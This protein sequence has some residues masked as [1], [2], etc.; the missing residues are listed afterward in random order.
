MGGNNVYDVEVTANDNSGETTVQLIA[1]TVTP[2]NDNTPVFTTQGGTGS[3][4]DGPVSSLVTFNMPENSTVA[5]TVT[6]TD[7]DLPAQE[8]TFSITGGADQ[9]LFTVNPETGVLSFLSA[10][11]FENPADTGAN[12][13]YEVQVTANDGQGNMTA[14]DVTVNV[15]NAV[16]V[17]GITLNPEAGTYYLGKE[18]A[19]VDPTATYQEDATAADYSSAQLTVSIIVNRQAKDTLSIKGQGNKP[20]Q[21]NTK[22]KNILFGGVVIGTFKGGTRAKPE[23][24]ITFNSSATEAA[25]NAL[26]KRITFFSKNDR[27][28]SYAPRT[29]Q[30]QVTNVSGLDGNQATRVLNIAEGS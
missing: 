21:I 20:G 25:V 23:L 9:T 29:V 19:F 4:D 26:V 1:V 13:T 14:Q 24:V 2:V 3:G 17:P 16:E 8:I 10:P 18:N 28:A 27:R 30:M 5:G 22:G 11:D 7:G 6:A 15:T 12:N